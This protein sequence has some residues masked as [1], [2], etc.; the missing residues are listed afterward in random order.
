VL[1]KKFS[2]NEPLVVE[3]VFKVSKRLDL[4]L[5]WFAL[6]QCILR[7]G[8]GDH[9]SQKRYVDN[10]LAKRAFAFFLSHQAGNLS[11]PPLHV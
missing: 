5:A 6:D 2:F 8:S 11:I 9:H 1:S 3:L 4:R 7:L 10:F